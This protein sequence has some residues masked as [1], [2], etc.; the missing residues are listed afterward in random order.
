MESL[1]PRDRKKI[2]TID[3]SCFT[4]L[5]VKRKD[6]QGWLLLGKDRFSEKMKNFHAERRYLEDQPPLA[7]VDLSRADQIALK[8]LDGP[9]GAAPE[10]R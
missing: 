9:G 2:D 7:Y 1:E 3:V 8:P 10:R 4:D 6:F 5:R